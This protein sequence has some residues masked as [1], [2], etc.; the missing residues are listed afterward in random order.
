MGVP[1]MCTKE[2]AIEGYRIPEG[3]MIIVYVHTAIIIK[4]PTDFE[5]MTETRGDSA[6]TLPSIQSQS[7][8]NLSAIFLL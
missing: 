7:V 5:A 8:S 3:A 2:D 6:G 4:Q 1:H